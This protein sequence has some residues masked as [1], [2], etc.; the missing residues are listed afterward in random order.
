MPDEPTGEAS[1]QIVR[2]ILI[3]LLGIYIV[4]SVIFGVMAFTRIEDLERKQAV[5]QDE[6]NKKIEDSNNQNRA[7]IDALIQKLGMTRQDLTK[8]AVAIQREQKAIESRVA[9]GEEETKREFGAVSGVVNGVKTDVGK[10][11]DDVNATRS[12]LEST[13]AKLER[14][15][16]DLNKESELIATTHDQLELLKHRGDKN[17]Y[18]FT[19]TR[20]LRRKT[21][22]ST[23]HSSFTQEESTTSSK[24]WSTVWTRTK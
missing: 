24:S 15:I 9:A 16:G 2:N 17:Y 22:A 6:L 10:V 1:N 5:K 7:T 13:K 19:L 8:K 23:S 12:D 14:A 20:R 3:A 4:A 11:K 18:E 21:K